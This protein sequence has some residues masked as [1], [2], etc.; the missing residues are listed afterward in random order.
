[1]TFTKVHDAPPQDFV[2]SKLLPSPSDPLPRNKDLFQ[3][4]DLAEH[5]VLVAVPVG[6]TVKQAS[7]VFVR[8]TPALS[9]VVR[10]HSLVFS[11]AQG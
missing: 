4:A 5:L 6:I 11:K 2:P 10:S 1:M 3:F 7:V 8:T 9:P